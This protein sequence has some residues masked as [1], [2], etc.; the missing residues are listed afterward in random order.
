[1]LP[2][3]IY[4]C[5][6]F[7]LIPL[8]DC[9]DSLKHTLLLNKV[10]VFLQQLSQSAYAMQVLAPDIGCGEHTVS[11]LLGVASRP[12]FL[13]EVHNLLSIVWYNLCSVLAL[14]TLVVGDDGCKTEYKRSKYVFTPGRSRAQNFGNELSMMLVT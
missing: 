1:M 11:N 6:L 7:G 10:E 2:P 3:I 12:E 8:Q 4:I 13:E 5:V 14:A 9:L